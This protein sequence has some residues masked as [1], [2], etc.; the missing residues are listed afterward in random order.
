MPEG[1]S[2]PI[3]FEA[4]FEKAL[5]NLDSFMNKVDKRSREGAKSLGLMELATKA[6]VATFTVSKIVQGLESV[7]E[8]ATESEDV[9]LKLSL[10]LKSTGSATDKNIA[11][12]QDMA[13]ELEKNSRYEDETILSN[14]ALAKQFGVTNK[15]AAKLIKTAVDLS[16]VTGDDLSTSVRQLGQTLDG[17][18]GRMAQQFP[19]LQQLTAAQLRSGAAIKILGEQY[20]GAA[21]QGVNTFSGQMNQLTKAF[22]NLE[23]EIGLVI[24]KNPQFIHN[25][26]ALTEILVKFTNAISDGNGKLRTFL[27]YISAPNIGQFSKIGN[28]IITTGH[29]IVSAFDEM[30][31]SS[32]KAI[33]SMG[34]FGQRFDPIQK[35]FVDLTGTAQKTSNAVLGIGDSF[36]SVTGKISRGFDEGNVFDRFANEQKDKFEQLQK[37]LED[38]GKT[39]LDTLTNLYNKNRRLI[40]FAADHSWV[41]R[42]KQQEELGK[43]ELKYAL[44][45]DKLRQES[46]AKLEAALKEGLDNPFAAIFNKYDPNNFSTSGQRRAGA[47]LGFAKQPLRGA[48]GARDLIGSG[49]GA[50]A[51]IWLGPAGAAVG[52]IVKELSKGKD[53]VHQMITE[54]FDSIP[55]FIENI[56]DGLQEAILTFADKAP[57]AL[58]KLLDRT[59]EIIDHLIANLPKLFAA[60]PKYIIG[61]TV[62]VFRGILHSIEGLG[63]VFNRYGNDIIRGASRFV[64]E[65][66]RGAGKFITALVSGIKNGLEKM[67]SG[68]GIFGSG[69]GGGSLLGGIVGGVTGGVL[70]GGV[71]IGGHKFFK[72]GAES[73]SGPGQ[74]VVVNLQISNKT[75]S[76]A[77]LDL[78]KLGFAT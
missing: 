52:D 78:Q 63:K 49:V 34:N 9:I 76:T 26:A 5:T 40:D 48:E 20:R 65:L 77:I 33:K 72:G 7:I 22:G 71:S 1:V 42:K 56:I 16:A 58:E 59:P 61:F 18:A 75:L 45:A 62:A 36:N 68:S 46:Y 41:T 54:F 13:K 8:K 21:A 19:V 51:S 70:G 12:F 44:E 25:I 3:D 55:Q 32:A 30:D 14:V 31:E 43:L 67:F 50:V 66:V 47:V 38:I 73:G 64:S 4:R 17:T 15:E 2:A 28:A 6:F 27:S 53:S 60:L 57:E 29:A 11:L 23:E 69:S 74:Q 37:S 39:E 10:A 35:K 24:I